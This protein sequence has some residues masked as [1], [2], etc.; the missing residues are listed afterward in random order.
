MKL[1]QFAGLGGATSR[2]SPVKGLRRLTVA[3]AAHRACGGSV[4]SSGNQ[5]EAVLLAER[6]RNGGGK[7]KHEASGAQGPIQYTA[8]VAAGTEPS[9]R[10]RLIIASVSANQREVQFRWPA[11]RS[12]A[13]TA[14]SSSRRRAADR[15]SRQRRRKR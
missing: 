10:V 11:Q 13:G 3:T 15:S 12:E 8:E 5:V 7:A 6:T 14:R 4:P 2:T 9:H 1:I